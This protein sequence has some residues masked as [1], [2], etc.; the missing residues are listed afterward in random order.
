MRL[1]RMLAARLVAAACIPG[2]RFAECWERKD[3]A[4]QMAELIGHQ[5]DR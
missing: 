5:V 3:S 2:I 4:V 1:T